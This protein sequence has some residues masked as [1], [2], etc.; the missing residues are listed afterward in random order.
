MRFSR[1]INTFFNHF[2]CCLPS[3]YF[4][5]FYCI[6]SYMCLF[7]FVLGQLLV[8]FECTALLSCPLHMH[9][10]TMHMYMYM[11]LCFFSWANK[12]MMNDDLW[13]LASARTSLCMALQYSGAGTPPP[14]K[15]SRFVR[16]RR[17]VVVSGVGFINE[18]NRHWAQL[19]LG[20]TAVGGRVNHLG[21]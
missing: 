18:V 9:M 12:M 6:F 17:G 8:Q 20:W 10:Y 3:F 1:L 2:H 16:W 5:N 11:F 19:V 4:L 13:L 14:S 15:L 21:M 7:V